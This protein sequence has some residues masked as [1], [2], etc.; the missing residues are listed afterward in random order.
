MGHM[1]VVGV[2]GVGLHEG[3]EG[4]KEDQMDKHIG[5]AMG[6]G[7]ILGFIEGFGS[8]KP[9]QNSDHVATT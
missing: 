1:R 3:Y 2:R 8:P 4:I 5:T 7:F 6:I 9:S